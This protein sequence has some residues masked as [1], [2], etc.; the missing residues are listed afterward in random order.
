MTP[1]LGIGRGPSGV[2]TRSSGGIAEPAGVHVDDPTALVQLE[3]RAGRCTGLAEF[4]SEPVGGTACGRSSA[5]PDRP[6]HRVGLAWIHASFI[7]SR[8]EPRRELSAEV[9]GRHLLRVRDVTTMTPDVGD[10]A[11]LQPRSG[12]ADGLYSDGRGR[13]P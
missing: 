9:G 6:Y 13:P 11:R 8:K 5:E 4:V 3:Q 7:V 1:A 2:P 12:T 10:E